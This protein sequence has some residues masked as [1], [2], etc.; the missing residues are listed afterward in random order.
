M[1]MLE[2]FY[3]SRSRKQDEQSKQQKREPIYR[4]ERV[5]LGTGPRTCY[6]QIDE[7]RQ[8]DRW[9][10]QRDRLRRTVERH[11]LAEASV[12]TIGSISFWRVW[13]SIVPTLLPSHWITA[14]Y[15]STMSEYDVVPVIQFPASLGDSEGVLRDVA[16]QIADA[17][18]ALPMP[19]SLQLEKRERRVL[20]LTLLSALSIA[21]RNRME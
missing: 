7:Y 17:I 1:A 10:P 8:G 16:Q 20:S 14:G 4:H 13:A 19:P 9:R 18:D 15:C 6:L 2:W 3:K 11:L 5:G 21:V 12:V